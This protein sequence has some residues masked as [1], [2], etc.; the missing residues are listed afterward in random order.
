[1]AA[2]LFY[3]T[4]CVNISFDQMTERFDELVKDPQNIYSL[5][6]SAPKS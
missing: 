4:R 3:F 1:M 5:N 6:L 2:G